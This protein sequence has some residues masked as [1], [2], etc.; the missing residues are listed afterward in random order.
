MDT[1]INLTVM[2]AGI[3]GIDSTF[4]RRR[5]RASGSLEKASLELGDNALSDAILAVAKER[6]G[7]PLYTFETTPKT[8]LYWLATETGKTSKEDVEAI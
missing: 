2:L 4:F 6:R 7:E 3:D 8:M 1:A 5:S